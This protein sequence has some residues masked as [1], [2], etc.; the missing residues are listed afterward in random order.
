MVIP[1]DSEVNDAETKKK[2]RNRRNE[3]NEKSCIT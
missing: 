1:A 3:Q 2:N